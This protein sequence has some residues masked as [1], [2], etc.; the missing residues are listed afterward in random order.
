[1]SWTNHVRDE[2]SHRLKEEMYNLY[3]IQSRQNNW[4]EHILHR[5]CPV[6]QVLEGKVGGEIEVM[7][8]QIRCKQPLDD[9]KEMGGYWKLQKE[10]QGHTENSSKADCGIMITFMINR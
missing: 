8:R 2:V 9:L 7:G 10:T 1:M 5:N 4:T 6:K 3:P